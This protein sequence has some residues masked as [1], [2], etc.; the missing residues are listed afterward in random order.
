MYRHGLCALLLTSVMLPLCGCSEDSPSE[1]APPAMTEVVVLSSSY[2]NNRFF[3]LDLA[4]PGTRHAQDHPGRDAQQ[5]R[6]AL[7]SIHV[8]KFL[9]MPEQ[10]QPQDILYIAAYLDTTGVFWTAPGSPP[11]DF[12]TPAVYG[13]HWRELSFRP[14][15]DRDGNL[16]AV[17]LG[18]ELAV[19]DVLA[20]SY[21]VVDHDGNLRF[22]V[23]DDFT[24]LPSTEIP[25]ETEPYYRAKLLK[26]SPW[27]DSAIG[28]EHA[29]HYVERNIYSLGRTDIDP[30]GFRMTIE[31]AEHGRQDP[32]VD[33]ND[34]PYIRLFGLDRFDAQGV[35]LPDGLA[36]IQDARLFD[37]REGLLRFPMAEPFA[38]GEAAH[39]AFADSPLFRWEDTY[40]AEHQEQELYLSWVRP[41]DYGAYGRFL[42]RATYRSVV[43]E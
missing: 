5:E 30:D 37:L 14:R 35:A 9:P 12:S 42:L 16:E 15:L 40:L 19:D 39:R 7:N 11:S 1:P 41:E 24:A 13:T 34:F 29:F 2:L 17:D 43:G 6:I 21:A 36:D 33:E 8:F 10:P 26:A 27:G 4:P 28:Y 18:V 22:H 38:A 20:V 3:R 31:V 32:D 23:G 25:G